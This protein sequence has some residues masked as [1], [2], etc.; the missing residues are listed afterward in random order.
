MTGTVKALGFLMMRT[1]ALPVSQLEEVR[2][3]FDRDGT[4]LKSETLKLPIVREALFLAS[5]RMYSLVYEPEAGKGYDPKLE[6]SVARYLVRMCTRSTPFGVF[7]GV[8][9]GAISDATS[10][11]VGS[12]EKATR[13]VRIDASIPWH[14]RDDL[15]SAD[16]ISLDIVRKTRITCNSSIWSAP[17]GFRYVETKGRDKARTYLT[18]CIAETPAIKR[19]LVVVTAQNKGEGMPFNDLTAQMAKEF[20]TELEAAEG[21]LLSLVTSQLLICMPQMS[22]TG[23]DV[24]NGMVRDLIALNAKP[25]ATAALQNALAA[26]ETVGQD[27]GANVEA[28]KQVS[29]SLKKIKPD[30]TGSSAVQVDLFRP[31]KSL[32]LS[33]KLVNGLQKQIEEVRA[34]LTSTGAGLQMFHDRFKEKFGDEAVPLLQ[35]LDEDFG[36]MFEK[37]QG[38]IKRENG[39]N[40][41]IMRRLME[42]CRRGEKE[43]VLSENDIAAFGKSGEFP[44]SFT[45]G[46]MLTAVSLEALDKGKFCFDMTMYQPFT[47]A[48]LAGRFCAGNGEFAEGTRRMIA[49]AEGDLDDTIFAEIVHLPEGRIGN[50]I[51]RPVLR[52]HEIVYLGRSGAPAEQ[53]IPASDIM[54]QCVNN[55]VELYSQS[56]SKRIIPRLTNA[57]NF[58]TPLSLPIYHFLARLQYQN[59]SAFGV[60]IKGISQQFDFVP[61]V[62][63]RNLRLTRP[64]WRLT[65]DEIKA[66][67]QFEGDELSDAF[68]KLLRGGDIK[69][70]VRILKSDNFLQLD[71]GSRLDRKILKEE[72]RRKDAVELEEILNTEPSLVTDSEGRCFNHEIVMSFSDHNPLSRLPRPVVPGKLERPAWFAPGQDWLYARIFASTQIIERLVC[73]LFPAVQAISSKHDCRMPFFLRYNENGHHLRLRVFGE[74]GRSWRALRDDLE[75]LL[76]PYWRNRAISRL[77]YGTY[78]P[79]T[80]RYGGAASARLCEEIFSRDSVMVSAALQHLKGLPEGMPRFELALASIFHLLRDFELGVEVEIALLEEMK[81]S[82]QRRFEISDYRLNDSYRSARATVERISSGAFPEPDFFGDAIRERREA[83]QPFI[84]A[85]KQDADPSRLKGVIMSLIHMTANRIFLENGTLQELT[86]THFLAKAMKSRQGRDKFEIHHREQAKRRQIAVPALQ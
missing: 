6:M 58:A 71:L 52:N 45:V 44:G 4:V 41:H 28:Y 65:Q 35:A 75:A 77:E 29:T 10:L 5:D 64:S 67:A 49:E 8:S 19:V 14:L 2:A 79:E 21:F 26:L 80:Q 70:S 76:E 46:G 85:L 32:S 50:V 86:L 48:N 60:M 56:R 57:H 73:D 84:L 9:A 7:A 20:G 83:I 36:V 34:I 53:Q 15:F 81:K 66:I 39:G 13:S 12:I 30:L 25:E 31:A 42:A 61:G 37:D 18:A 69:G 74:G 59:Q 11:E 62:R 78:F 72:C 51:V 63:Y 55:N 43:I 54:V 38:G 16:M 17:D 23:D 68:T 47:S 82:Y 40:A 33:T 24:V 3:A 22:V 1:P 27:A